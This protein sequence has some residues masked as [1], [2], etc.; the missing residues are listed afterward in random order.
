MMTIMKSMS[1][2]GQYLKHR[3]EP[4]GNLR[5]LSVTKATIQVAPNTPRVPGHFVYVFS[6]E[7][8]A[9]RDLLFRLFSFKANSSFISNIYLYPTYKR[10]NTGVHVSMAASSGRLWNLQEHK[11]E[12]KHLGG[13]GQQQ[14]LVSPGLTLRCDFSIPP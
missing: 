11:R 13:G 5:R 10:R 7:R 4:Q 9:N 2:R 8:V 6:V 14:K 12:K 3:R 1:F